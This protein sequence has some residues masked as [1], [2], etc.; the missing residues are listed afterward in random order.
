MGS[1]V[2][3]AQLPQRRVA[4]IIG[5]SDYHKVGTLTNAATDAAQIATT[6]GQ[7]GFALIPPANPSYAAPDPSKA[8]VNLGLQDMNAVLSQLDDNVAPGDLVVFYFAGHCV[9]HEQSLYL[10]PTDA[11]VGSNSSRNLSKTATS[12]DECVTRIREKGAQRIIIIIDGCRNNPGGDPA[13]AEGGLIRAGDGIFVAL[14]TAGGTAAKDGRGNRS[15]MADALLSE[16]AIPG[17]SV[18]EIFESVRERVL[19]STGA[20]QRPFFCRDPADW[21][22][23]VLNQN[24]RLMP[25]SPTQGS[26]GLPVPVP[27]APPVDP[28]PFVLARKT[29]LYNQPG[30]TA[31]GETWK[32]APDLGGTMVEI[33]PPSDQP[34]LAGW[35]YIEMSGWAVEHGALP[36]DGSPPN[37]FLA[38]TPTGRWKVI[39]KE[40]TI[41][42]TPTTMIENAMATLRSGALLEA[43]ETKEEDDGRSWLKVVWR[44][45]VQTSAD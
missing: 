1:I 18:E 8:Y 16:L 34:A 45:W 44:G 4:V 25:P 27:P 7:L 31:Q 37:T 17:K 26:P 21:R 35:H 29:T 42:H 15:P 11:V 41:R 2:L 9:Q 40:L 39:T 22:S 6:L 3:H 14:A 23:V 20:V 36:T 32:L 24:V 30:G 28:A 38:Q 13:K 5:N 19:A 10:M 33:P 43:V 12:F